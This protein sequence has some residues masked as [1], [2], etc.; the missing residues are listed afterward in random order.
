VRGESRGQ[1][2]LPV[3]EAVV[4]VALVLGLAAAFAVGV[5]GPATERA[6]LERYADDA[7]TTLADA[8]A[9]G[10]EGPLLARALASRTAFRDARSVLRN[11]TTGALP[12]S[13]RARLETPRGSLGPPSPPDAPAGRA[14]VTTVHGPVRVVVWYG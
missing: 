1:L 3:V 4:G 13:V 10:G 2:S 9:A 6:Q 7:A 11:R 8:P 5:P 14:T 12:G